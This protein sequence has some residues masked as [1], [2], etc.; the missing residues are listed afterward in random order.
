[1][2]ILEKD[3][4]SAN[5]NHTLDSDVLESNPHGEDEDWNSKSLINSKNQ[6]K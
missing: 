1:M 5:E 2:F 3:L 4:K 6:I